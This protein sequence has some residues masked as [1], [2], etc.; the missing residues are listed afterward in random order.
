MTRG[1]SLPSLGDDLER[2][3]VEGDEPEFVACRSLSLRPLIVGAFK[4]NLDNVLRSVLRVT[5]A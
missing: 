3:E 2:R 5:V 1:D 4:L